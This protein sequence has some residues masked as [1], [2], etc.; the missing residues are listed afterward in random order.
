MIS[1]NRT[2][3]GRP[4]RPRGRRPGS[5]P[6]G[7]AALLESAIA[8]SAQ[9]G[10]DGANLRGIAK[11]AGVDPS[12]V[13]IHFGTKAKLWSA[14]VETMA[15]QT[16]AVIEDVRRLAAATDRPVD[17]RLR[18]LIERSAAFSLT[19]PKVRDFVARH[20]SESEERAKLLTERLV[21]PAYEAG[22]PLIEAGIKEGILRV[23]HPA[24]F[25]S[26]LNTVMNQSSA[27]PT[28][29]HELDPGIAPAKVHEMLTRSIVATF[30]HHSCHKR[31]L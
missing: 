13:R 23:G 3:A 24:L 6:H 4:N 1:T 15:V 29:L 18:L 14:C 5:L 25:F 17:E 26:L 19:H 2:I 12:L 27:T 7:R 16:A 22:L 31:S 20:A 21:R 9:H 30:L 11:V 8:A 28:L 10:F